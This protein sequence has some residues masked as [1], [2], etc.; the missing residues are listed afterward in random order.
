[1][2]ARKKTQLFPLKNAQCGQGD[3]TNRKQ[4]CSTAQ[5]KSLGSAITSRNAERFIQEEQKNDSGCSERT[6][7]LRKAR[8]AGSGE[9]GAWHPPALRM[10]AK[11]EG[12]QRE[13]RRDRG[14]GATLWRARDGRLRSSDFIHQEGMTG[15][16]A[17]LETGISGISISLGTPSKSPLAMAAWG[18]PVM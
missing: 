13:T 6:N 5:G 11:T 7:S 12:W 1:M 3:E 17:L 15:P 2:H 4:H 9:A 10:W 14:V 18:E 16:E 8:T